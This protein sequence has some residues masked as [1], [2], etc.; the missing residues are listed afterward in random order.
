MNQ[1]LHFDPKIIRIHELLRQAGATDVLF[2]GGFVRDHVLGIPSKDMDLEIYGLTYQQIIAALRPYFRVGQV[3]QSFSVLK[4][5]NEIDLAIPRRERKT[6]VGHKAF[7]VVAD[8]S[9][10]FQEAASRRDFTINAIGMRLDGTFCDPFGGLGDLKRGILRA[11]TEAFCEDPLRVLRGMQFAARFGFSMESR[12][13]EFCRKVLPEFKTLSCERLYTEWEKWA[14][15]G[16]WPE[17]G[18]DVLRETGWL[19]CFPELFAMMQTEQDPEVHPE[20]NVWEHTRKVCISAAK[21]AEKQNFSAHERLCLMFSALV[22]DIGKPAAWKKD[23]N[24]RISMPGHAVLGAQTAF[25][26]FQKLRAPLN[27]SRTIRPLV[28]LHGWHFHHPADPS[29]VRHLTDELAPASFRLWHALVSADRDGRGLH[30]PQG[31]LLYPEW[32]KLAEE[33]DLWENRPPQI[34]FGRDLMHFGIR[35]GAQMGPLLQKIRQ[36]ELNGEFTNHADGLK[37]LEG[38]LKTEIQE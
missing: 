12:T 27:V 36:A 8:S 3:G 7:E 31:D 17:K 38:F 25:D 2:V 35:P 29:S 19:E 1:P 24:G 23:E 4:I 18:L 32:A 30:T 22:H 37:W 21:I 14:L 10:S 15:K 26:F 33:L 13:V 6:G 34:L 5:D 28:A 11:P 16:K 9:M 20:G